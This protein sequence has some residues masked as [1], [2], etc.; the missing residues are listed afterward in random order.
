MDVLLQEAPWYK[1]WFWTVASKGLYPTLFSAI[2]FAYLSV[3]GELQAQ[4]RRFIWY[5]VRKQLLALWNLNTWTLI[6]FFVTVVFAVLGGASSQATAYFV[7]EQY[8]KLAKRHIALQSAYEGNRIDTYRLFS[9]YL[10]GIFRQLDLRT[11]ERVS[12]YK[13]DLEEYLCI[14][15]FSDNALYQSKPTR[16]YP[17][18]QGF[19]ASAWQVGTVENADSPDPKTDWPAYVQYHAKY[20]FS[21]EQLEALRMRSRSFFG[22]R[23]R[24]DQNNQTIAVLMFESTEPGGL[25]FGK[26]KRFFNEHEKRNMLALVKSLESHIPSLEA[27]NSEGF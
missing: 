23:L 4:V 14:G 9:N 21:A 8:K 17:A 13:L 10:Y 2:G 6:F 18:K 12:L 16:L 25:K 15:R 26:L 19:I 27:A 7:K 22:V 11:D 20:G 5:G 1:K 24:D 3:G